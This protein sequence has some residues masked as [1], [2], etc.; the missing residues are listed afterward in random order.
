MEL[1]RVFSF[2]RVLTIIKYY[3]QVEI[4][5]QII[6]VIKNWFVDLCLN[7]TPNVDLKE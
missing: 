5:D 7:G 3:L 1:E 2:V 6:I 4:F